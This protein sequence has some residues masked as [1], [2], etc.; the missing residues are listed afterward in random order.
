VLSLR[1][2]WQQ[3]AKQT[4]V[5]AILALIDAW[6]AEGCKRLSGNICLGTRIGLLDSERTSYQ[7]RSAQSWLNKTVLAR[8]IP[9]I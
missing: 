5:R 4:E 1:R 9:R 3:P 7:E 6:F 8:E 2:R